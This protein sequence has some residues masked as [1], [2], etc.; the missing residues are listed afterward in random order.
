MILDQIAKAISDHIII[1]NFMSFLLGL[2]AGFR[3][4]LW[5]DRR[6]DFN[7]ACP[8]IRNWLIGEIEDP[9]TTPNTPSRVDIEF[10]VS[11]LPFWKRT[12]FAKYWQTQSQ[13]LSKLPHTRDKEFSLITYSNTET[14]KIA[15]Q[16]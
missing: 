9:N 1:F 3:F 14:R 10:F 5:R 15:L 13:E 11:L 12:R 8:A 6:N 16:K 7:K 4:N 2:W